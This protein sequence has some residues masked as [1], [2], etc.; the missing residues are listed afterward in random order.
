MEK[1]RNILR[2][3]FEGFFRLRGCRKELREILKIKILER[4]G[5][6]LRGKEGNIFEGFKRRWVGFR[7]EI[8]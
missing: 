3:N 5:R 4:K 7:V 6:S 1:R 2:I 8:E